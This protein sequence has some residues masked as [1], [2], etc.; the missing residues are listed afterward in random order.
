MNRERIYAAIFGKTPAH[1]SSQKIQACAIFSAIIVALLNIIRIYDYI[2]D[3]HNTGLPL[4]ATLLL[5]LVLIFL[6][7]LARH[8]Y[9][10]PAA[11]LLI[12]AYAMPTVYCFF[13]WGADLPAGILMSV[14]ISLL[15]GM[16]LGSLPALLVASG[17]S[18]AMISLSILQFKKL[19]PIASDW[20][21]NPNHPVDSVSYVLI[22]AAIFLLAWLIVRENRRALAA[23]KEAQSALL[24]ERDGLEMAVAERTKAIA[25]MQREKVEQLQVL[26][27]IGQLSGGIFHDIVNPLTSVSLNL[28][29]LSQDT[30]SDNKEK[31]GQ[32]LAATG[33]IRDLIESATSCLRRRP[34]GDV[35]GVRSEISKIRRIMR[36]KAGAQGISISQD[37]GPEIR[38]TGGSTRFGQVVMNLISNAIEACA[39]PEANGKE[40]RISAAEHPRNGIII[41]VEDQGCGIPADRLQRIFT[42]FYSTKAENGKNLGLGLS[43]VKEIT[44]NDF[45]GQIKVSSRRG[46]GSA[47]SLCLPSHLLAA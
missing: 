2:V 35:F 44:E 17:L 19:I 31:L 43:V 14:L 32:A 24:K 21:L 1:S 42:A 27:A 30:Q 10:R 16:F 37:S 22:F 4:Y 15:A 20:R 41:K 34:R 12:T 13:L 47:F 6:W 3:P 38:L 29:Q 28:E 5:L 7:R 9:E 23:L 18:A 33:R 36:A 46:K 25:A 11:W 40:I 26:A 45:G 39:S 8:G